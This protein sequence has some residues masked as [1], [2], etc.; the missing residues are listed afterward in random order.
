ML[1]SSDEQPD[2]ADEALD[3]RL[4]EALDERLDHAPVGRLRDKLRS[5]K[6]KLKDS[7]SSPSQ[8]REEQ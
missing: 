2:T 7:S 3:Q 5:A 6:P 1:P 4:R 8:E